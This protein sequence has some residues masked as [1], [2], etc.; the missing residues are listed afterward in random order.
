MV[1]PVME[2]DLISLTSGMDLISSSMGLVS[3]SSTRSGD[4]PGKRA[5]TCA[6]RMVISGS[7]CRAC[8]KYTKEPATMT[9]SRHN[10]VKRDRAMAKRTSDVMA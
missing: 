10:R 9:S 6:L 4:M 7:S 5:I 3:S 1:M 8:V 2:S